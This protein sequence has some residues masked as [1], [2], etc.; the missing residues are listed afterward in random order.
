MR[1]VSLIDP[2]VTLRALSVM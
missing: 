1:F 2:R